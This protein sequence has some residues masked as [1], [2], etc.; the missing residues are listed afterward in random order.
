M[1]GP[2]TLST[3]GNLNHLFKNENK[4]AFSNNSCQIHTGLTSNNNCDAGDAK[5]LSTTSH[6]RSSNRV[7][8]SSKLMKGHSASMCVYL[9]QQNQ[10]TYSSVAG[11][12]TFQG[13]TR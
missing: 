12:I 4:A 8:K 5:I 1:A 6:I 7:N 3:L 10:F 2:Q 9:K 11:I 13:R